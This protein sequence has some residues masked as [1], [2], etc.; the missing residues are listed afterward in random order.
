M[1]DGS[2]HAAALRYSSITG[3]LTDAQDELN[4]AEAGLHKAQEEVSMKR[5]KLGRLIE[6]ERKLWTSLVMKR[7]A[8]SPEKE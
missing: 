5:A 7:E 1:K 2:L 8:Y 4:L 3:Y 6:D